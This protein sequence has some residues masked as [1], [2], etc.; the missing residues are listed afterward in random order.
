MRVL[1]LMRLGERDVSRILII[2]ASKSALLAIVI[3]TQASLELE[4]HNFLSLDFFLNVSH[5]DRLPTAK[6]ENVDWLC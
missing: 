4:G 5:L 3:T 6:R 2:I 1:L